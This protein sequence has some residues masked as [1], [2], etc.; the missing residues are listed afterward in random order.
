MKLTGPFGTGEPKWDK[1]VDSFQLMPAASRKFQ[2]A[3]PSDI[4]SRL[5]DTPRPTLTVLKWEGSSAYIPEELKRKWC[6]HIVYGKEWLTEL[7]KAF[8][9]GRASSGIVGGRR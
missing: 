2:P 8:R 1:H 5:E 6:N 4:A 7:E 9:M 3:L